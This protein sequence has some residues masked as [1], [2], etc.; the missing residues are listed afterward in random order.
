MHVGWEGSV[1][2]SRVMQDA[3]GHVE[4]EFPWPPTC[5]LLIFM[6]NFNDNLVFIQFV[7][8]ISFDSKV[9]EVSVTA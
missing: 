7:Y 6:G 3:I 9:L 8:N 4:Y 1:N 5:N 2:D